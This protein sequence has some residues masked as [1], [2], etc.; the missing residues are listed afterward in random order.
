MRSTR[1]G[2]LA[3][4]RKLYDSPQMAKRFWPVFVALAVVVP[5]TRAPAVDCPLTNPAACTSVVDLGTINGDASSAQIVRTGTGGAFFKLRI[6]ESSS[7]LKPLN[8]RVQLAVP[9]GVNYDLHVRCQACNGTVTK[10]STNGIGAAELV[11][12]TKSD[13]WTSEDTFDVFIEVRFY[14]GSSCLSW[15]LTIAGNTAAVQGALA[16]P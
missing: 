13:S 16:C 2:T 4:P 15:T 10:S 6:R 5:S 7:S 11:A 3:R 12:M 8:A 9:A 14:A 1:A